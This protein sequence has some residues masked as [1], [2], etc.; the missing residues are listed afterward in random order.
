M[1]IPDLLEALLPYVVFL[2]CLALFSLLYRWA[3]KRKAAAIGLGMLLHSIIPVPNVEKHIELVV[4]EK[5]QNEKKQQQTNEE[6][7]A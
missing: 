5:K 2:A 4:A 1:T 3:K 6:N 7:K